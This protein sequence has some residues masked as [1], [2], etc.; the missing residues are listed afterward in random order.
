MD[1]LYDICE[2]LR[3]F[4]EPLWIE[5]HTSWDQEIPYIS[6]LHMC[7]YTSIFLQDVLQSDFNIYSQIVGGR[8]EVDDSDWP[9]TVYG[10][11]DQDNIYQ[12][13][14][15]LVIDDTNT[16]VDITADQFGDNKINITQVGDQRYHPNLH[17]LES[18]FKEELSNLSNSVNERLSIWK[19]RTI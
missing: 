6:S 8:P 15:R 14:C 5:K 18:P 3:S 17:Q 2:S 16:I 11:L 9:Y 19:N 10:C 1:R 13:H 4:L 7:R 12:D